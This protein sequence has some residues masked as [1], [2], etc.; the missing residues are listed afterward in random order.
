[1]CVCSRGGTEAVVAAAKC[2]VVAGVNAFSNSPRVLASRD[3]SRAIFAISW[4]KVGV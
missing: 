4:V 1:M 3:M 2:E